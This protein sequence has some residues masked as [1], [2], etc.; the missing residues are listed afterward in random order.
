MALITKTYGKILA[1]LLSLIGFSVIL[2]SCTKYGCGTSGRK[3]QATGS[4]VS[5]EDKVP[6]EGI[7]AVLKDDNY[8][9]Y[10]TV[11]TAKDGSFFLQHPSTT[12]GCERFF[13]ELQDVDGETNGLFE[14]MEIPIA[15]KNNK[16]N[17]GT[18]YMIPKE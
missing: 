16:Q 15:T 11:Y 6:I 10:D 7:R 13:V 8:Q 5:N 4:V 1:V 18:I 2:T 12:G 9:G 14:D 3:P 17:L